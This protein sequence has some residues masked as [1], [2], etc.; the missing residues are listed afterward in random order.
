M[1]TLFP[2]IQKFSRL[3]LYI[4]CF[5][6]IVYLG[7]KKKKAFQG[8]GWEEFIASLERIQK[9]GGV[10][11]PRDLFLLGYAHAHLGRVDEALRFME[12]IPAPLKTIDE[13]ACRCCTHA[14]LLHKVGERDQARSVLERFTNDQWPAYRLEWVKDFLD[15]IEK[16]GILNDSVFRPGLSIH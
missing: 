2:R 5:P 8:A 9:F 13:E 4:L 1:K 15:A 14:W 3:T 10:V 12:I 16:G 6:Y 7:W 11:S